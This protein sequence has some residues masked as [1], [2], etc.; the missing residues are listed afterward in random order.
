VRINSNNLAFDAYRNLSLDTAR[1]GGSAEK[2]TSGTR[3]RAASDP[4]VDAPNVAAENASASAT[5][6]TGPEVALRLADLA[7]HQILQEPATAMQAQASRLPSS[8]LKLLQ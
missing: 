6:I 1:T 5:L 7:R 3:G 8:A 4:A 2:P